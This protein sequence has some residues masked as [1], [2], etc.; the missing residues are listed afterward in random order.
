M[1]IL[2]YEIRR[3]PP[4]TYTIETLDNHISYPYGT[5]LKIVPKEGYQLFHELETG[6][7]SE[8]GGAI[9]IQVRRRVDK[10]T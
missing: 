4:K 7:W 1:K 5:W 9:D 3:I 10:L 6:V 8:V 2:G